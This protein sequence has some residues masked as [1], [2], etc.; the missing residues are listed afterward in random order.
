MHH[1]RLLGTIDLRD[2][3][4]QEVRAVLQQ[5]K[6]LALLAWFA[7]EG[8]DR[9]VRRDTVL[10]LFWPELPQGNARAALRRA[11]YFLRQHL[12]DGIIEGRGEEELRLAPGA[13]RCDAVECR[14]A[15]DQRDLVCVRELYRGPL[16]DG[17]YIEGAAEAEEWLD[18]ARR[19]LALALEQLPAGRQPP[20][21]AVP[22]SLPALRDWHNGEQ[23]YRLGRYRPASLHYNAAT[24]KDSHFALAYYRN[25]S[26]MAALTMISAAQ[27][28]NGVAMTHRA[29]L[30]ERDRRLIEAQ[31][32]WLHG[33][34]TEAERHYL[35]ISAAHPEDLEACS[36][37]GDLLL[38]HNPYR[39]RSIREARGPLE[40]TLE[41]DPSHISSLIK[42][43][44]LEALEKRRDALNA[45]VNA[46]TRLSPDGDRVP[47]LRLLRAVSLGDR[48][49]E[50]ALLRELA[51]ATALTL[52]I[53]FAD[54]ALYGGDPVATDRVGLAIIETLRR[55]ELRGLAWLA[56]AYL[57]AHRRQL[58]ECRARLALGASAMPSW[59]PPARALLVLVPALEWTQ[60]DVAAAETAVRSWTIGPQ[61]SSAFPPV[62]MH[63]RI[64]EQSQAWLLGLL[65]ARKG[66]V[67]GVEGALSACGSLS[68]PGDD[69]LVAERMERL[70]AAELYRLR[71]NPA[72]ALAQLEAAPTDCWFQE[73]VVSP[74]HCGAYERWRRGMLLREVG[75]EAE[76]TGW[77]RSLAERSPW[78]MPYL[79]TE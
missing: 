38:H 41:L 26:C 75:R 52:G 76:A 36:L 56:L 72:A 79:G 28:M 64:Q 7:L 13:L 59:G 15:L 62:R 23:E 6:R 43:A 16:L 33:R 21:P 48:D 57:S 60:D 5:P 66:D 8:G 12:G 39:G 22:I 65:A 9:F 24:R 73:A 11:V 50:A 69:A 3:A 46:I 71:G 10:A 47:G 25:A 2:H 51:G 53:A 42:L 61:D 44:R 27:E 54:V 19:S 34:V 55:P 20:A 40:R 35:S 29:Q 77:L 58:D 74:L 37:L 17:F 32:A 67:D 49:E 14:R 31:H 1:L 70:L 68:A 18:G 45:R 4:G 30:D 78:E 63:D